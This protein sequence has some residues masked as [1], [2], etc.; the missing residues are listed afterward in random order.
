M[1]LTANTPRMEQ[2]G[3][4]FVSLGVVAA[5]HIYQ[6]AIVGRNYGT[7]YVQP[8]LVCDEAM[9]FAYDEADNSAGAVNAIACKIQTS[10]DFIMTLTGVTIQDIGKAVYATADDAIALTGHALGFLGRVKSVY[11]SNKAVIT[12][13]K[14]G[15]L[16]GPND[17]GCMLCVAGQS[18]LSTGA[19]GSATLEYPSGGGV[20]FASLLGL[21]VRP[22]AGNRIVMELDNTSEAATATVLTPIRFDLDKGI[23][24]DVALCAYS[25]TGTALSGSATDLDWGIC[26]AIVYTALDPSIHVHMHVDGA[27]TNLIGL[28]GDDNTTDVA[29]SQA[30]SLTLPKVTG[31]STRYTFIIRP[32]TAPEVYA[33]G[34]LVALPSLAALVFTGL[35]SVCGFVNLEKTT[36]TD[37]G[38]VE[39]DRF[40][41]AGGR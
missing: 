17:D 34:V 36:S 25:T 14:P 21:G 33:A 9:G 28:G 7:G 19:T 23:V 18:T 5:K 13:K 22:A 16:P 38:A 35:G 15:E 2:A 41:M 4:T 20:L 32:A 6:G 29:E 40:L 37:V 11:A 1:A 8:F 10:G 26:N 31:G 39:I 27:D 30:G 3:H 12:L 24:F